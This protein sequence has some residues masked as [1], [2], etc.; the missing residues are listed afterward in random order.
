MYV[1]SSQKIKYLEN[2]FDG[3]DRYHKLHLSPPQLSPPTHSH[4]SPVLS[5]GISGTLHSPFSTFSSYP[6]L[7]PSLWVSGS[8]PLIPEPQPHFNSHRK[9]KLLSQVFLYPPI[10]NDELWILCL[11]S[12]FPFPH[13]AY[14]MIWVH[15]AFLHQP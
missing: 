13:L 7:I 6:L 14:T 5:S 9:C 4:L 3:S 12:V 2:L 8:L 10:G 11:C 15:M 1:A